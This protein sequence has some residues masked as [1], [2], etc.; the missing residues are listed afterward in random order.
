MLA[1]VLL[2]FFPYLLP[3]LR[4]NFDLIPLYPPDKSYTIFQLPDPTFDFI[5]IGAGSA[6]STLGNRL[7]EAPNLKVLLI[8]AGPNPPLPDSALVP[9]EF[10]LYGS[11]VD[12]SYPTEPANNSCRG[13]INNQMTLPRGKMLGGTSSINGNL[14]NRG[15][16][17]DYDGWASMGNPGWSYNDVLPYFKKLERV[18]V[19]RWPPSTKHGYDGPVYVEDFTN[20]TVYGVSELAKYIASYALESGLP[21]VEDIS[22]KR[23][24]GMTIVPATLKDEIRWSTAK[25]YL[26]PPLNTECLTIMKET[27]ATKVIFDSKK[28][29]AI[30]VEVFKGGLFK[31]IYSKKEVIVSAGTISSP[32]ILMLSGIGPKADLKKLDIQVI[33]DLKVGYNLQDHVATFGILAETDFA[34]YRILYPQLL[35]LSLLLIDRIDVGFI[36]NILLL[37]NTKGYTSDDPNIQCLHFIFPEKSAMKSYFSNRNLKP[38][39]MAQLMKLIAKAPTFLSYQQNLKPKSRGR[40]FLKSNN[41][42]QYPGIVHG[43]LTNPDDVKVMIE[44]LRRLRKLSQTKAFKERGTYI[45]LTAEECSPY[46]LYSDA[47]YECILRYYTFTSDHFAGTCKMGPE[48]DPSAVVSAALK[49]HGVDGLRVVDASVMPQITSGNTNIPTIMIAEKAADMIKQDYGYK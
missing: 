45:P 20:R 18:R 21:V 44:G 22:V 19:P 42:L 28:S 29:K 3:S 23:R 24:S 34:D 6:G 48:G 12:W 4:S 7:C 30:G 37:F 26:Q 27:L 40:V 14:Y 38:Q 31:K 47:Y 2:S 16:P 5:I 1:K 32:Q 8:E 46:A 10:N 36:A 25:A 13:Y 17:S 9:T 11:P 35:E 41:P 39:A 43:Y 49:V 15:S 33:S